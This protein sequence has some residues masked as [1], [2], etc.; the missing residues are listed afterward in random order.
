[1]TGFG[2]PIYNFLPCQQFRQTLQSVAD[3]RL[4]HRHLVNLLQPLHQG[5]LTEGWIIPLI[6]T[7][8]NAQGLRQMA[9]GWFGGLRHCWLLVKKKNG[10]C[11]T[12]MH[13]QCNKVDLQVFVFAWQLNYCT[14]L[15]IQY[16]AETGRSLIFQNV[17]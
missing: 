13:K 10:S 1:M 5:P 9:T 11:P 14:Y 16:E 3:C 2:V 8:G 7:E 12:F 4:R 17:P 15:G 6:S